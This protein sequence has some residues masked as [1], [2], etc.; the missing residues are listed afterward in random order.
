MEI[1]MSISDVV[2]SIGQ[3]I[4]IDVAKNI[5]KDKTLEFTI[6]KD[7][8]KAI[9]KAVKAELPYAHDR[10][11]A[12][13]IVDDLFYNFTN[14]DIAELN[15][16]DIIQ[17][18]LEEYGD[19]NKDSDL[20]AKGIVSQLP[21]QFIHSRELNSLINSKLT[22]ELLAKNERIL[23][24]L[25]ILKEH[26]QLSQYDNQVARELLM[27]LMDL[28]R[29]LIENQRR[30]NSNNMFIP[31]KYR[32]YFANKL[33]L[34]D[35]LEDQ[36]AA[37]LEDVYIP[38]TFAILEYKIEEKG[39]NIIRFIEDF[40]GVQRKSK[41]EEKLFDFHD[42]YITTLFIKGHPGSGKSSLFYYLAHMKSHEAE[43]LSNYHMYFIKL[44]ELY[45]ENNN[46][47][48][49]NN[50]LEDMLKH[51]GKQSNNFNNTILVLD[52]LDEICA[53]RDLN[54]NEYCTNLIASTFRYK[55]FKLIITT[56]LNYINIK[57][58][59]NKNVLNIQLEN[60]EIDDLNKWVDKYFTIHKN[61]KEL[62][63]V[64]NHNISYLS[65][66][67]NDEY[68]TILAVPLLFYMI[69]AIGLKLN[70]VDSIGQLYDKVFDELY[71]RNYNESNNSALQ[72]CGIIKAIPKNVSRQI[73]M[74][75]AY[76]MYEENELLL[77]VNSVELGQAI[78]KAVMSNEN[79]EVDLLYKR[80]IE[81]LFPIT[82][83]YKEVYDVVEFAHKSIMEFFCAE[84]IYQEFIL[85]SQSITEF[86]SNNMVKNVITTEVMEFFIYFYETRNVVVEDYKNSI[87]SEFE[88]I[89][90]SGE[91]F[92]NVNKRVY[93]YEISKLVFK[94]Y[95]IFIKQI[96]KCDTQEINRILLN[97][98]M[99]N[100]LI[101]ILRI[102]NSNN[103]QFINNDMYLLD[104]TGCVF[105]GYAFDY[106]DLRLVNFAS[107][108]FKRSKI[109][110]SDLTGC[111]FH[112]I[113]IKDIMNVSY[114]D[115]KECIFAEISKKSKI[116]MNHVRVDNT[117]ITNCDIRNWVL[118]NIIFVGVLKFINVTL[119]N[120]QVEALS[121]E[122]TDFR[123]VTI[124]IEPNIINSKD[125]TEL[126][127]IYREKKTKWDEKWDET[128][129]AYIESFISRWEIAFK[130][131]LKEH[132]SYKL[133]YEH[134]KF[135][136]YINAF[137]Y[138]A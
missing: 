27:E 39:K 86:I 26:M 41:K 25:G 56:R 33:F 77:K 126:K 90:L 70:D 59:D 106:V 44:I 24:E 125:I 119:T 48:S 55:N 116:Y 79:I 15:L 68:L 101:G 107:S 67:S 32:G 122:H 13:A 51:L 61:K 78:N 20:I 91:Y 127:K 31:E 84:K 113:D 92:V 53:A 72:K 105:D 128:V 21:M 23:D 57:S 66:N 69:T 97:E 17:N 74:E 81:K 93:G 30:M 29:D 100:Y 98:Y 46:T 5:Y 114:S 9:V 14:R 130:R 75:I 132:E 50:P 99:K 94:I 62:K 104:F 88:R 131:N 65:K 87:I 112:K 34:E 52:G 7:L 120:K 123:D 124:T 82:F 19:Y 11:V 49:E 8:K 117:I 37:R 43:F 40:S 12:D 6:K 111:I 4:I 133:S 63:E 10:I 71:D 22:F 135:R 76:K 3:D 85:N 95:W 64:A 129:D 2:L 136:A 45:K 115:L 18:T 38:P 54:I 103:L 36:K 109:E 89:I 121:C 28:S 137:V 60:W 80:Q 73:A 58:S 108:T 16:A 118:T 110:N 47:L 83:F 96:F 102:R 42:K 138:N 35:K 1:N 134:S